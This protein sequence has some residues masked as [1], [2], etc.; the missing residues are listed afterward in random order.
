MTDDP[1][2]KATDGPSEP[3]MSVTVVLVVVLA[4]A[5]VGGIVL[6]TGL[7]QLWL[8]VGCV[9][10]AVALIVVL[11]RRLRRHGSARRAA[12]TGANTP[13]PGDG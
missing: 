4:A 8:G 11:D 7:H 13:E 12:R 3:T 6:L 9:A 5:G 1:A 2:L 10:V